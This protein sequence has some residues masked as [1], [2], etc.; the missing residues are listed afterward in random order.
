MIEAI[1]YATQAIA[2]LYAIGWVMPKF[3]LPSWYWPETRSERDFAN[4]HW[5][6]RWL[7]YA[8]F[9]L[10][11]LGL[12]IM[13][14]HMSDALVQWAAKI[15]PNRSMSEEWSEGMRTIRSTLGFGLAVSILSI[16]EARH[17]DAALRPIERRALFHLID[18]LKDQ[19]WSS[20]TAEDY[21]QSVISSAE[22]ALSH[23]MNGEG[24]GVR[25]YRLALIDKFSALRAR[26]GPNGAAGPS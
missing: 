19:P 18:R 6:R 22:N 17:E 5:A 2:S 26:T 9:S 4:Q 12:V 11:F 7:F 15:W 8:K 23:P 25:S 3:W 13:G 21:R 10:I 24:L 20:Q 16:A 1:L 14:F